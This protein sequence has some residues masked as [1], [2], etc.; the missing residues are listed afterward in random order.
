MTT[1]R[2]KT[3]DGFQPFSGVRRVSR[4][5]TC[6]VKTEGGLSLDCTTDHKV[7]LH[8][9]FFIEAKYLS[10]GD[11]ID[12]DTGTD[13]VASV[14]FK[15]TPGKYFY[16]ALD[17]GGGN[18]YLTEGIVSHNCEFMGSSGTLVAGWK[19]KE[20]THLEPLAQNDDGLLLYGRPNNNRQ[21]MMICDVSRGK[22]LDYSAF[23]VIDTTEMPYEQVCTFRSNLITPIEY[24]EIIFRVGNLF[25][26]CPVLVEINDIGEQVSNHLYEV[27]EYE[28]VLMT[29]SAGRAGKRISGGFGGDVDM[30]IRTTKTVK[31][32]GC[33]IMKLLIEQN[34]FIVNDF[35]TI[36]ELSTFSKKGTSYE[37]ESGHNDDLVMGLVLFAWLSSQSYFKELNN[38]DTI[39]K[40]R[41]KTEEELMNSLLPFGIVDDGVDIQGDSF[42]AES[43]EF[44]KSFDST[45]EKEVE[46]PLSNSLGL[47]I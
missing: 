23:H 34:Q 39:A 1:I 38:I 5:T 22:G 3:Q 21:Y 6:T 12:T 42:T 14:E 40:L 11:L 20:L 41:D 29:E 25:N 4:N 16:D 10:V 35:N 8:N 28:N 45:E 36:S 37:A 43:H 7:S 13:A 31:A 30:G 32:Q 2:I 33:S 9:K 26:D 19:L 46:Y 18:T 27:F 47:P 17:V 24:A 15:S 44:F